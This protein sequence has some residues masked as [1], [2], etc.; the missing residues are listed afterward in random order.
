MKKISA[1]QMNAPVHS[2]VAAVYAG[3][4]KLLRQAE[5]KTGA[6]GARCIKAK[7][8]AQKTNSRTLA[9]PGSGLTEALKNTFSETAPFS[10]KN[11]LARAAWP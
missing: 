10:L 11:T 7:K 2:F 4:A 9:K 5:N 3:A 8:Y 6:L 1:N